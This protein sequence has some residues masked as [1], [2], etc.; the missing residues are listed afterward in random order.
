MKQKILSEE[1]EIPDGVEV[2]V[3]GNL[4]SVKGPKGEN[5]R[6]LANPKVKIEKKDNKIVV[7]AK[8]ATKREKRD[9]GTFKS[10]ITSLVKGVSEPF[11]Y[12][13]KI[14]SGHFPM[15]VTATK[16]ELK[17]KNFLGETVPRVLKLRE[18]VDVK[19][20]GDSVIVESVD[21]EA[22]GQTAADIE[23]LTR[24]TNRDRRIFQD[25]IWIT[26]KCGKKM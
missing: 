13:L 4:V 17:V 1:I 18:G 3:S 20:E 8:K 21:K 22:A 2:F 12:K 9:I 15:N 5:K 14:C 25:G 11:V 23:Q 10:H 7:S 19:V 26:E 24:I 16:E 6:N